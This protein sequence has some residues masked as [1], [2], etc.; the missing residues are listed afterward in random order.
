M[1]M[2][3]RNIGIVL[4]GFAVLPNKISDKIPIPK[5]LIANQ[6]QCR[7]LIIINRDKNHP[8]IRQKLLQ[9]LQ[10]RIHHAQPFVVAAQILTFFAD[11]FAQP[12]LYA[13]VV[14]IVVVHP[15]LIARVIRRVDVNAVHPPAK[16]RQQAFE[17][18]QV[19]AV[20]QKIVAAVFG[21]TV[22]GLEVVELV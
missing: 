18:K 4:A 17:R 3:Q 14:H 1:V 12:F 11:H 22:V 7:L 20:Y 15:A 10:T 13:R 6:L 2:R 19:V 21:F 9:Q 5:N 8:V 16:F